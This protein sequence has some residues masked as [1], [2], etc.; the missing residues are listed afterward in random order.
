MKKFTLC[1][2]LLIAMSGSLIAQV[3][4]VANETKIPSDKNEIIAK[5]QAFMNAVMSGEIEKAKGF[6]DPGFHI[7]TPYTGMDSL[8]LDAAMAGWKQMYEG[9]SGLSYNALSTAVE[10]TDTGNKVALFWGIFSGTDKE[11]QKTVNMR[12]HVVFIFNS[13]GKLVREH[14]FWDR[15]TLAEQLGG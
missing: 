14:D 3:T 10:V 5:A 8:N 13:E 7:T 12:V 6:C 9:N 11:S 1:I 4:Y 2:G 15:Q